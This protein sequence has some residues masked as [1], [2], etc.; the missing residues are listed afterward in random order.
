MTI[1]ALSAIGLMFA[2]SAYA[3][4]RIRTDLKRLPMQ[5]SLKGKVQWTAP[6]LPALLFTPLLFTLLLALSSLLGGMEANATIIPMLAIIGPLCH[7]L[8]V[9][10][11]AT[12]AEG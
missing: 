1:L 11:I 3:H 8:H 5:W 12:R 9:A 10:L 7:G 2:L 6:R 4:L